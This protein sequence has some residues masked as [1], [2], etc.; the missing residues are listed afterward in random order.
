M[1]LRVRVKSS[2]KGSGFV[3]VPKVLSQLIVLDV[4]VNATVEL[5]TIIQVN[6]CYLFYTK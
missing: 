4:V 3:K 2:E 5:F 1:S 6:V